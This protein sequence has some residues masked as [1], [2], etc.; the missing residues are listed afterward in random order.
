MK[1]VNKLIFFLVYVLIINIVLIGCG[2]IKKKMDEVIN[3]PVEETSTTKDSSK[4]VDVSEELEAR[5]KSEGV[6]TEDMQSM[7]EELTVMT[8]EKYGSTKEEYIKMLDEDSKTPFDEFVTAAD[9]MGIT[10]K[11]YYE[12][13]KQNAANLTDEQK[14]IMSGMKDAM[15]ELQNVD[16]DAIEEQAQD[17]I[18][19]MENMEK[20]EN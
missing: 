18:N 19:K 15:K 13:E 20:G 8:A 14:E 1:R 5:A 9:F 12:Y 3:T 16:L 2:G 4:T 10:I 6:S 17:I 11:E 7:I